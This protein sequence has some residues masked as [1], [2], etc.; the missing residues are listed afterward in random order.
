MDLL[1]SVVSGPL[2]TVA[3]AMIKLFNLPDNMAPWIA[4]VFAIVS[5]VIVH[6]LGVTPD[7][8]TNIVGAIVTWAISM[9]THE[10]AKNIALVGKVQDNV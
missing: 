4:L 8:A 6:V 9:G 7:I 2:I 10:A 5:T 3:V 1:P